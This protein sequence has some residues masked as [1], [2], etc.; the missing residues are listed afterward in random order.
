M[1]QV[2][3]TCKQNAWK[4]RRA[5]CLQ[6]IW[7]YSLQLCILIST[8]EYYESKYLNLAMHVTFGIAGL[9]K[10]DQFGLYCYNRKKSWLWGPQRL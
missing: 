4:Q 9:A 5:C 10:N 8:D 7:Q 6:Q 3:K 1:I 2:E